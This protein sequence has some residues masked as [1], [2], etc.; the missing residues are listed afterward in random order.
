MTLPVLALLLGAYILSLLI[1]FNHFQLLAVH[2]CLADVMHPAPCTRDRV[3]PVLAA[4][5]TLN[6]VLTTNGGIT[7][8]TGSL[9]NVTG[10]VGNDASV[11]NQLGTVLTSPNASVA[12]L[13]ADPT[14]PNGGVLNPALNLGSNCVGISVLSPSGVA[15]ICSPGSG[16][17][18]CCSSSYGEQP[19]PFPTTIDTYNTGC[20]QITSKYEERAVTHGWP[21]ASDS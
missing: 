7:D 4:G 18:C 13:L 3:A 12:A 20:L 11:L 14:C 19:Q 17:G 5:T 1:H 8:T 15:Q 16:G 9:I 10:L 6:N 21:T 2:V